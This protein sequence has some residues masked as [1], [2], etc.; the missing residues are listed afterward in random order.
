MS[1]SSIPG[2]R[3]RLN[4]TQK[5]SA[6][7]ISAVAVA[8]LSF[9][10]VPANAEGKPKA[11][12]AEA[13]APVVL[14]S[15][16][17]TPQAKALQAS[18]I[19]QH[20]TAEKLV[21]AADL[22]RAKKAAAVEA[23]AKA[24]AK[25][26]AEAKARVKSEAVAEKRTGT[27]AASRSEARTPVYANNLDGWI[28][29]ALDIMKSRGIPGTYDGLHR[30]IMRESSG[31]PNAINGWDINARNGVPSIGLLQII[32][33]TFDAYHV[34]GT[35][36]SQYNPVANLTAAANYAADRYG[37]IDNVNSAY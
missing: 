8:S 28:R 9:S 29:E 15:V 2:R 7:A 24:A 27:Q 23:K 25:A 33:P 36:F 34:P 17:G 4:K 20:S 35:A 3:R 31:N 21:K 5:L 22:A 37:S 16:A 19:G 30:N 6:A 10:L 13:A 18:L 12:A 32:K 26:K 1:E 11:Q 14:T